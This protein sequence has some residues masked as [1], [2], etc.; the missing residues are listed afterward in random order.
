ME[1]ITKRE[2]KRIERRKAIIDA[3]EELFSR[4]GYGE[5]TM[6]EIAEQAGMAKGS[7]YLHFKSKE[8]L[9]LTICV[10]GVA[11][12]GEALEKSRQEARGLEEK[13]RSVYLAYIRHSLREPAVFRVLRDIFLEQVR[14]NLSDA[15]VEEVSAII[16][17]WLCRESELVREGVE[18]GLFLPQI[19]PYRF[20]VLAWRTATG[21]VELALL[22][23]PLVLGGSDL[24]NLFEES[25]DL[26]LRGAKRPTGEPGNR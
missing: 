24:E 8:E 23:E 13:I 16:R 25:I 20:S 19:D 6:Q 12:F 4:K 2:R 21:L 15:T 22:Q 7:L 17:N 9:Y 18:K 14:Q 26:L 1:N 3:A 11:G 10:Q 5:T